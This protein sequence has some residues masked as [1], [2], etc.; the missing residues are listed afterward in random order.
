MQQEKFGLRIFNLVINRVLKKVYF[1]LDEAS[2]LDLE[3]NITSG[4]EKAG[5]KA[6]KK[7]IPNFEELFEE[8]AK[9]IEKEIKEEIA[10]EI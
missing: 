4:D 6:V 9:I 2:R 7:Y 1:S 3:K 8:Q 10:K 5:E